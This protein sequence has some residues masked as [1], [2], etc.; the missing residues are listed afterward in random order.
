M[1]EIELVEK[2]QCPG[3][4]AGNTECGKYEPANPAGPGSVK[5]ESHVL[6]TWA[7][8]G[9]NFALGLPKGFCKPGPR[10]DLEKSDPFYRTA[11][12]QIEIRLWSAGSPPTQPGFW[13]KLNVPVWAMEKEGFLFVRTYAPR[14][15]CS[16]VDVIEGGTLALVP[17]AINVAEFI[18][19]ID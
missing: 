18:D 5:C 8:I 17:G 13:D 10:L 16:W 12:Y 6:G 9:N 19:E 15:N 7:G 14:V 11:R 1:T 2:F 3:C 4:V